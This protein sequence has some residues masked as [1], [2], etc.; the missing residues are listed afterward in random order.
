MKKLFSVDP[1]GIG[2]PNGPAAAD[3]IPEALL[4]GT[5]AV[6]RTHLEHLLGPE[7]VL[8]R[9]VDLVRYASD[10][11]PYRLVPQVVVEAHDASDI[12]K[13]LK[14][15][16]E[17]GR[18][19]TFRAAGTSL[20]GQAQSDDILIDVR[21][22]FTG[23]LSIASGGA[24]IKARAGTILA[25]ANVHLSCHGRKIGPDPASANVCTLGGVVSNNAGGMR[26]RVNQDAYHTVSAMSF[27]TASGT[28]I[29]TASVEA[30]QQFALH[31]RALAS[32]LMALKAEIMADPALVERIR[33]KY[34]IRNTHGYRLD[35]FLDGDTPLEIFGR[36][37]V[38]SEGTLGFVSDVT[39]DTIPSA[40][41]TS[42]A[43]LAF[44]S[45]D[46]A[47]ALVPK[48]VELGA[49]AAELMVAPALRAAAEAF[50][51]TPD[52]WRTLQPE[53]AA[54]L[55]E[56]GASDV[57]SLKH[58]EAAF[59]ELCA[60]TD[61]IAEPVFTSHEEAVELAWFVREGLL[62]LVGKQRPVGSMLIVEDVCFPP[63]RLA[64][65]ARDL[66]QL[67]RKHGFMPGVAGHAAH[68]NL[69][70]TLTAR[71]DEEEGRAQYSKFMTEL[72]ELVVKQYDGSLKAE[73][74]TG[75]NMAPFL[76]QE[77]GERATAIMWKVKQLAD[78]HGVLAPNVILTRDD[79]VHLKG[80]KTQPGIETT[81]NASLCIECGF[82]ESVCPSRNVTMTP[83]QR[84]VVRR[85][86]ARQPEGSAVLR[87][88]QEQY[89]YDAIQTCAGD[90]TCAL[91]CP[92]EIDT[93]ALM[94]TFRQATQTDASEAAAR[95]VAQ[96]WNGVEQASKVAL[97]GARYMGESLG[98]K[99]VRAVAETARLVAS[100]DV[101][102]SVPG[103]MPQPARALP[104]TR[105]ENAHAVY[106]TA[107]VNRM[108]GRDPD[109]PA[110]ALSIQQALI[111][112]SWRAGKNLWIPDD[113]GGTCCATPFS[114]KGYASAR[115]IMAE[116]T[117]ERL[118]KWSDAGRLPIVVDAASCTHGLVHGLDDVLTPEQQERRKRLN[119][120]DSITWC[121]RLLPELE[122]Y[123]RLGKIVIHPTC[124]MSHLKLTK[125]LKRITGHMAAEVEIP[126]G[127]TC[128]GTAGDRGLLHP[129]LVISAT[130]DQKA[131]LENV[132]ADAYVCANRTCEM[133]LKQ[134]MDRPY[135]SFLFSLEAATRKPGV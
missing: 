87:R 102:P 119:I 79:Q 122:V 70:F 56:L 62:G 130:R 115:Q 49:Q 17:T 13:V 107:C 88:L 100:D 74:G 129:E 108:F 25:H 96:R 47:I 38:G 105:R 8:H 36:L 120:I 23:I 20:N 33:Q 68:G 28:K 43:W 34:A 84:I 53:A 91:P 60:K 77:W 51:G 76:E 128:C 113:I 40:P 95:F 54:L 39:F 6:L 63:T 86:M 2:R 15:C 65:A 10:A 37:L 59:I 90:G 14:F 92:I 1:T 55:V 126:V 121:A 71:L 72:V 123:E 104:A 103:P 85:E 27:V 19:A 24:S 32:G 67:L 131:Y 81:A 9:V 18:H 118:W 48:L 83:R 45:I 127:A 41:I 64:N 111:A 114:S 73:H 22:H 99:A 69:H 101:V 66:Q 125:D 80:L 134:A 3:A 132:Q 116:T 93:G 106:F 124:A 110:D 82:C 98:W 117:L 52:Y 5:P 94:R 12:A 11:S 75:L 30:E 112:V 61:L 46:A 135:E 89:Q 44:P 97:R 29:D 50:P 35:A 4:E 26:C 7:R 16:G 57:A 21:K 109:A 31:E 58:K 78:P 42:V 133:G